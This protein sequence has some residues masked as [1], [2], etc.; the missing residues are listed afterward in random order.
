MQFW[1]FVWFLQHTYLEHYNRFSLI[2]VQE[3]KS[4]YDKHKFKVLS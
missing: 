1:S 2:L 3:A 4:C